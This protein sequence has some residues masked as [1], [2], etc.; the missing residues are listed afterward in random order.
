MNIKEPENDGY[1]AGYSLWKDLSDGWI[2]GPYTNFIPAHA[3]FE[4]E[5]SVAKIKRKNGSMNPDFYILGPNEKIYDITLELFR[6][7]SDFLRI[8]GFNLLTG[9]DLIFASIAYLENAYLVTKDRAFKTH[10]AS[11]IKVI[12][13]NDSKNN[14]IYRR[15][16][17][18]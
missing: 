5:A 10:V 14:P 13:L 18:I 2:E 11:H 8:G 6:K 7:S 15:E 17:G 4:L 12:D 16:F 3:A 1:S 9:Q